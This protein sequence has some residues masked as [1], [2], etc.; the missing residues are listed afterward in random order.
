M[1]PLVINIY[2]FLINSWKI[3]SVIN[4]TSVKKKCLMLLVSK[5]QFIILDK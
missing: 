1:E 4:Y 2:P 3:M 5:L